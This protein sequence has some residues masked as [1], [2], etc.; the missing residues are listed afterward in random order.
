[1][2]ITI[3]NPIVNTIGNSIGNSI[4]YTIGNT[5]GN[6]IGNTIGNSIGNTIANK[7]NRGGGGQKHTMKST[8][9]IVLKKGHDSEDAH[10]RD[11]M[12]LFLFSGHSV[13]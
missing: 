3:G 5:I 6:A 11:S 4:G 10:R 8:I 2:V 12:A 7:R 13:H 9:N 1:M